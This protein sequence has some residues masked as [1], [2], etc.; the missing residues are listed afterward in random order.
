[1]SILRRLQLSESLA[2]LGRCA[3]ASAI[4]FAATSSTAYV[5][6]VSRHPSQVE[7]GNGA[8]IVGI[9][10]ALLSVITAVRV[11]SAGAAVVA[12]LGVYFSLLVLSQDARAAAAV[13]SLCGYLGG[14]LLYPYLGTRS[15]ATC[16]G[17]M[18]VFIV[19]HIRYPV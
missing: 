8:V 18:L 5:L 15:F 12:P 17:L 19:L 13:A 16:V 2:M 3:I 14:F 1:M 4:S 7:P 6:S 9:V 10:A 11:A